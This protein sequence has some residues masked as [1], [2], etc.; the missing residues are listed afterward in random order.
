MF[1]T[2]VRTTRRTYY[3]HNDSSLWLWIHYYNVSTSRKQ[4]NRNVSHCCDIIIELNEKRQVQRSWRVC[5]AT[6]S[7]RRRLLT[8]R[9]HGAVDWHIA[10]MDLWWRRSRNSGANGWNSLCDRLTP[11]PLDERRLRTVTVYN[12]I[13][14]LYTT[15]YSDD[16]IGW[17]FLLDD[18]ISYGLACQTDK[19]DFLIIM[20]P[21]R[22][23]QEKRMSG[24][25]FFSDDWWALRRS[26]D[27]LFSH[28]ILSAVRFFQVNGEHFDDQRNVILL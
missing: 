2:T 27:N 23:C 15:F 4:T 20:M 9:R 17:I 25:R 19:N 22:K 18:W 28:P 26:Y 21:T 14:L 11:T 8:V 16:W 24:S 7:G 10:V 12:C 5:R 3:V 6:I 13:A 1:I